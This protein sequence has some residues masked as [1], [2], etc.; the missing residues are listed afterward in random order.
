MYAGTHRGRV[1]ETQKSM[2]IVDQ[3]VEVFKKVLAEDSPNLQIGRLEIL[4]VVHQHLL[5]GHGMGA[6]RNLVE[7]RKGSSRMGPD[8]ST[9]AVPWISN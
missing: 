9:T 8:A 3:H 2:C 6:R 7:L 1:V 4:K 5:V